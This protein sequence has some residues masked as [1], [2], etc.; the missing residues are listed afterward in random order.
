MTKIL[1]KISD[2][3]KSILKNI[4]VSFFIKGGSL[5]INVLLLPAYIR[6]FNDQTM[7]GVW[8]TV[9]SV[10]NW[11]TLFDLGLG[12]GLRNM[13]PKALEN[14]DKK[15]ISEYIST[16][17]IT[18]SLV[19]GIVFLIG[20]YA[21]PFINWNSLFNVSS[22]IV[23]ND[24]LAICVEIIYFGIVIHLVLKI[25]SSI[26]FALQ[27][28]AIVNFLALCTNIII[29][30]CVMLI[31]S[32]SLAVNLKTMSIVNCIAANLPY[33]ICTLVIFARELKFATPSISS[34]RKKYV[35]SILSIG[36][37]LLWLQLVF[38][39]INSTN[40]FVISNFTSPD[41]VVEYQAYYKI[42]KTAAMVIA[43][44]L[45]PIWSAVT[46][47]QAQRNYKWIKKVYVLFLLLSIGCLLVELSVIPWVQTLMDLWLGKGQVTTNI[48]YALA[49][50]VSSVIM[51]LHNINTSIGN[52]L[53]YF[54]VQ[55]VGM[56]AAAIAFI[57]LSYVLIQVTNSWIGVVLANSIV[58]APYE[59]L[60]PIYTI[61]LL[62]KKIKEQSGS[63][64]N[65]VAD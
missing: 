31:P 9:L 61:R 18:M 51:V 54:K 28:S 56:T 50:V 49:F 62:N 64:S 37:S 42:F 5:V 16:T 24:D 23:S 35:K 52:G 2:G 30:S 57:P 29:L 3:N 55:M 7:L 34:F 10:L 58:L 13:L 19:A 25:I 65:S 14:K 45:T 36:L 26:L 63:L 53:S 22:S 44:A 20:S 59:V 48:G 8:Y 47:A 27:K 39:I 21:I 12:N 43:L 6:F 17:Y 38:M 60:A 33:V 1:S 11:I 41:Y 15:L 32:D 40:E 4:A 46:K